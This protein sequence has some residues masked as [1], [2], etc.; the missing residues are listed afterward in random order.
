MPDQK[1]TILAIESS[2]D[3]TSAAVITREHNQPV[4]LSNIVSSQID[5]H[6]KTGGVVPEVASRAHMEAIIHVIQEALQRANPKIQDTS[7]KKFLNILNT[8][9]QDSQK[10]TANSYKLTADMLSKITHIAVTA[11]PGLIGSLLVGFNTAKSLSYALDIPIIPI[12]HIEGHIYSAFGGETPRDKIQDTNNS[13]ITNSKFLKH[14][15]ASEAKQSKSDQ[16][17][18]G[19][20]PFGRLTAPRRGI[21]LWK[22]KS[23]PI[24]ALTVSGGHTSL[25]LIK[26]HGAYEHIG[27]TLDDAAGEAFDKVAKLLDLGYPGGPA[28]SKVAAK[29]RQTGTRTGLALPLPLAHDKSYNFSFS[30]LKTSVLN[31]LRKAEREYEDNPQKLAEFKAELAC[32]FEETAVKH[33]IDKTL[34]ATKKYRV[35]TVLLAGG[36]SANQHLRKQLS[37]QLSAIS[38]QLIMP[39]LDLCGDNAAMI[40][41]AAY[42]H[43]LRNDLKNYDEISVDSNLKL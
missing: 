43:V 21:S 12:N 29:F 11:G 20:S 34:K 37:Y 17:P 36:V 24:L 30:G 7:S 16:P 8:N 9:S 27:G 14:V 32:V 5:L 23:F 22:T 1:I 39:P 41:V 18:E 4:I 35:K 33:L 2:C 28:V 10:L 19:G 3:E 6:A 38:L 25:T 15:I 13:Q 26:D 31:T 40:G 42:Y